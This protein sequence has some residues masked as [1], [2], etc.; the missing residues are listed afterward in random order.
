MG[1]SAQI[2]AARSDYAGN[3]GTYIDCCDGGP[4]AGSDTPTF[5]PVAGYFRRKLIL[6]RL[7]GNHLWR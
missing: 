3:A 5:D 1:L 2:G 7:D 6:D 4:L